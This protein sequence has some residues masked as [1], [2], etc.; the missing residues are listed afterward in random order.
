VIK[1]KD[2]LELR[3][4][5]YRKAPIK[6]HIKRMMMETPNFVDMILPY[7]PPHEN[8]SRETLGEL[9]YLST[10]E[11]DKDFVKKHDD[12]VK[13]FVEML[14]EFEVYTEQR[15]EIIEVLVNQSRKFIM[16]AKYSYN[17]PRPQ[18][19][20][21]FYGMTLNGTET[22]SMKTP[23]YPSGHAV[24]G[25]LV[26]EVLKTQIPH[27]TGELNNLADD[28]ANSRI[29]GKAHFPS[30]R[31]FGKKI[32]KLIYQ[33]FKKPISEA[34]EIDV[35]VGDTILT[36]R[37]KNKKTVVKKI[38]VD[39]HGMPTINGRKV[40]TFRMGKKVNVFD[41]ENITERVDFLE[42]ANQIV[43]QQGLKT[44]VKFKSGLNKA[45]YDWKKDIIYLR[46]SYSTMKEFLTTIY[47]E[48]YHAK[49][50]KKYGA[51]AYE[52]KYQRAGDMA[53]HKGKDFH[54]DNEFEEKAERY[55]RKM[56]AIH[57]RKK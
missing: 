7:K 52:K 48:I 49:D 1:L 34:I 4:M 31:E 39:N 30:D 41:K 42:T 20:A 19:I 3:N 50:R 54:D 17:R 27:L 46:P 10:L 45:D 47:H 55:G 28:I 36:G 2:L 53:V 40:A 12:V 15:K 44:K 24:Q 22:D 6:K 35:N 18:Q 25:Y 43:K 11:N 37:F 29:V 14:E 26:A 16:T 38:G 13:V 33:G 23:S 5:Q 32:A 21:K 8:D 57:L 56:A 9:K 51:N